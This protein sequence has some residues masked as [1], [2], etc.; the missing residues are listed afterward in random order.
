MSRNSQSDGTPAPHYCFGPKPDAA[1]HLS[2]INSSAPLPV[3]PV[4]K[5]DEICRGGGDQGQEIDLG[6]TAQSEKLGRPSKPRALLDLV[7]VNQGVNL[8]LSS[9]QSV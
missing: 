4:V 5:V 2:T 7:N 8:L 6:L 1:L 9:L 3:G